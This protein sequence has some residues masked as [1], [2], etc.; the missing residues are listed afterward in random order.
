M[1]FP[2][3]QLESYNSPPNSCELT[4]LKLIPLLSMNEIPTLQK[5]PYQILTP[6]NPDSQ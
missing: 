1:L 3:E 6:L 2:I 5:I 4:L